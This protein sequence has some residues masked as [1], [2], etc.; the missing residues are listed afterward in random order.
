MTDA[1]ERHPISELYQG[2]VL[3][4]ALFNRMLD[5]VTDPGQRHL[6]ACM[7]QLE[8]ET[9]A[10]L[11]PAV[12]ERGLPLA[13]D[14]VIRAE[15]EQVAAALAPMAWLEKMARLADGVGG[16]YLPR[17][18]ALA[19]G[20][21]TADAEITASMVEHEEALLAAVRRAADGDLAGAVA[22]VEPHLRF[23]LPGPTL[24]DAR[25]AW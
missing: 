3:G 5:D 24:H 9:K 15:G 8:T 4:E 12:A 17:Y 7:L 23:P 10:R 1:D 6:V 20:A 13:E 16:R 14:P 21:E 11:R 25:P 2:E 22:A 19:A 18:Q